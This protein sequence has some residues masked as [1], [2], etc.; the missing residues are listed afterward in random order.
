MGWFLK[1]KSFRTIRWWNIQIILNKKNA[2]IGHFPPTS[3]IFTFSILKSLTRRWLCR[4]TMVGFR[5]W[6]QGF[7]RQRRASD[8]DDEASD[9]DDDSEVYK[10]FHT[11]CGFFFLFYFE[12]H[13]SILYATRDLRTQKLLCM[14]LLYT[15]INHIISAFVYLTKSKK[16]MSFLN[17]FFSWNL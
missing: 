8:D 17:H 7:R 5:R 11:T 12:K 4:T 3:S 2:K 14:Q 6:W 1:M 13:F 15:N 10:D 9:D 16:W